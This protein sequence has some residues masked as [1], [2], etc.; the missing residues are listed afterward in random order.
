MADRADRRLVANLTAGVRPP[1]SMSDVARDMRALYE[2]L[3]GRA[4]VTTSTAVSAETPVV[5]GSR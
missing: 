3:P 4:Q 1:R 2:S 5:V